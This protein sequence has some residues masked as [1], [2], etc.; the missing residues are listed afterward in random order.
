MSEVVKAAKQLQTYER[1]VTWYNKTT[2]TTNVTDDDALSKNYYKL[3]RNMS[4][5]NSF[6]IIETL[7]GENGMPRLNKA[8]LLATYNVNGLITLVNEE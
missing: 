1:V 8:Y 2:N 3:N 5:S 4:L 7:V 6:V